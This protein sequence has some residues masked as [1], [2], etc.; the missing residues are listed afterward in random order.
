MFIL[1][2]LKGSAPVEREESVGAD[3]QRVIENARARAGSVKLRHPDAE[4]T[5]FQI[6][7]STGALVAVYPI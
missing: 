5:A 7:D 3:V 6:T 1:E 2:W 4:P